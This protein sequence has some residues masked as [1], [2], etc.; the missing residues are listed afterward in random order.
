MNRQGKL[1]GGDWTKLPGADAWG[2]PICPTIGHLCCLSFGHKAHGQEMKS[3]YTAR[4]PSEHG[5]QE[6]SFERSGIEV[7]SRA[8]NFGRWTYPDKV[9]PQIEGQLDKIRALKG[10]QLDAFK[11]F[12]SEGPIVFP[13]PVLRNELKVDILPGNEDFVLAEEEPL[14]V[15]EESTQESPT[16]PATS[17]ELLL[18]KGLPSS[19][20]GATKTTLKGRSASNP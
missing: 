15:I 7:E 12:P 2:I 10:T 13:E 14:A 11:V 17:G 19:S 1:P 6:R 3:G 9:L 18:P 16:L 4:F 8:K 20:R 5:R